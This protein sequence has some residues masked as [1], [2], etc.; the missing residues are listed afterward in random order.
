M[1]QDLV[2][3]TSLAMSLAPP[4]SPPMG[5]A[6]R[7]L[8][9]NKDPSQ[10]FF[11]HHHHLHHHG[12]AQNVHNHSKRR[13]RQVAKVQNHHGLKERVGRLLRDIHG[14]SS[15]RFP[16][17]HIS[18]ATDSGDQFTR[19]IGSFLPILWQHKFRD[20]GTFR[21]ISDGL[22]KASIP[23]LA[24]INRDAARRFI[25]LTNKK[26]TVPYGS[27][28]LQTIDVYLP[29]EGMH[30]SRGFVFFVHG[31]AWGSGMPWMYRLCASPFLNDNFAVAIVGYRTYPDGDVQ[32]QVNDLE[33]A[34]E[35][36]VSTYPELG[37]AQRGRS[38]DEWL[39]NTIIGH[40]SGA[41]ISLLMLVQRIAKFQEEMSGGDVSSSS[42]SSSSYLHF[43]QFIGL[44]GVYS[45]SHHFDYE[46][47]RGVEELSP[48]KPACGFTRDSFDH[49][50]PAI[51]LKSLYGIT[52]RNHP[53][54]CQEDCTDEIIAKYM[55][56]VLLI[57]GV[58][59]TTVPFTS[60]SEVAQILKSCGVCHCQEYYIVCGHAHV[61]MQLMLGGVSQEI[62][63]K[64]LIKGAIHAHQ[65][66]A[67]KL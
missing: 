7:N 14:N 19:S 39:G 54:S 47:G 50:S 46:A 10:G 1:T 11:T 30:A 61:V 27:H 43:D 8:Y 2:T 37:C 17:P 18:V 4:R 60:T 64:W 31:G 20:D 22:I 59:D 12:I 52:N 6:H 49:Y 45:I 38:K 51:L 44:S 63:M 42:G 56:N 35:A 33:A 9:C 57:H 29:R 16:H 23:S 67:S 25:E 58:D 41:H 36:L 13:D 53:D 34:A 28:K 40:S 3:P 21:S 26:I 15:M 5:S 24:L 62:V 65:V 32:D 48:M 66:F 55:P